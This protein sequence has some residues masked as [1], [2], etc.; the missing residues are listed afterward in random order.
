MG[1]PFLVRLARAHTTESLRGWG[2]EIAAV[3]AP[4][5]FG[6]DRGFLV[7]RVVGVG[8]DQQSLRAIS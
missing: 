4:F 3:H 1:H 7:A 6:F 8:N 5:C 2:Q